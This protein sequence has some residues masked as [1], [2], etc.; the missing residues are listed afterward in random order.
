MIRRDCRRVIGSIAPWNYT[1]MM[2]AWEA[3]AGNRRRQ[4]GRLQAVGTDAADGSLK[5]G[6]A[7]ADILPE[8]S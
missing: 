5:M 6:E 1:L 8:A 4:Y 3:R 2:M 7:A